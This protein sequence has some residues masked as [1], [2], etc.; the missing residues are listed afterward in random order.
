M[1]R[2]LAAWFWMYFSAA[3][4]RG[5]LFFR[6]SAIFPL[7]YTGLGYGLDVNRKALLVSSG[8]VLDLPSLRGLGLSP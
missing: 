7:G 3:A 1:N 8:R 4:L 2:D 5:L 6:F